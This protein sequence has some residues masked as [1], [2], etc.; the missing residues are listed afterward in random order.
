[1]TTEVSGPDIDR[2][3]FCVFGLDSIS[4]ELI[5]QPKDVADVLRAII[6][7]RP[8]GDF[9]PSILIPV[10]FGLT[11]DDPF[12]PV[13]VGWTVIVGAN[14]PDKEAI[15]DALRP[16]ATLR[17]CPAN[18]AALEYDVA[19][20]LESWID[21]NYNTLD[22]VPHF[23]V[24]AGSPQ[25]LPFALQ[26]SLACV[27]WV[28]RLD[29]STVDDTKETQHP[30]LFAQY[31]DKVLRNE[32][33]E[34]EPTNAEVVVWATSGGPRD[35]TRYSRALMA[36][37]L[38]DRIE[39]KAK[40]AVTRLFDGDATAEVLKRTASS[41]RPRLVFTASHGDAVAQS[42]GV[43]EQAI[44]N[45]ALIGQDGA[46][47]AA[48]D[49]PAADQPFVEGGVIFSFAC[50]GYG[51]PARSGYTHWWPEIQP[52]Q[53]PFEL[54]SALPKAAIAH[55]RGP[56]GYIA[57]ADYAVLH[58][59]ANADRPGSDGTTALAPRLKAFRETLDEALLDRPVGAV[60][61]PIA[62][63]LSL[64]NLQLTDMWDAAQTVGAAVAT[65]DRLV[66]AF[67]RR[68]DA[69]YYLILGDPAARTHTRF[70]KE[71]A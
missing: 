4:N 61:E 65:N 2:V 1:M 17:G 11:E 39:S 45:G 48:S 21:A 42:R 47:F 6:D 59:F 18:W 15:V 40:F 9:I 52:Y 35:P 44:Q 24:L 26:V 23:V 30:D 13:L 37:P 31:V 64:L 46:R 16:L 22:P 43:D 58:A 20:D 66:D 56:I 62:G 33:G 50:F 38:A 67:L 7:V 71:T 8:D 41:S 69:R 32:R 14:D 10:S 49:L 5:A 60:L 63:Q 34:T 36:G 28:G 12:D 3:Q 54:V 25:H 53:A 57:H 29:F 68:N 55:P 70:E 27:A 51:T 19:G